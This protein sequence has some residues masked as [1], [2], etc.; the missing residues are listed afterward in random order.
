MAIDLTGINNVGEFYSH[1]YLDALLENDLKS[2]FAHWRAEE[3]DT[4]PA[5]GMNYSPD[6]ALNRCAT[7]FF[8]AKRRALRERR[9]ANRQ[10]ASHPIHVELLEALGYTYAP[11]SRYLADGAA[12]PLLGAVARDGHD[13]L[14]LAETPFVDG[15]ASPLEQMVLAAQ[16][17]DQAGKET[18]DRVIPAVPWEELVGEIFRVTNPPRWLILLAGRFIYLID[19]TKWGQ[20]Q[21]L[22]FDLDEIFGRRE[23]S[24]L[25]AT[26]ALLAREALCPTEGVPL[27]DTLD[28]N[29]HKHAYAVSS[30]LK[31]GA[32]RAVELLANE[33]VYYQRTVAK[34]ALFQDEQL[35]E[36]LTAEALTYLYRLLFLFYAEARGGELD[37]VPMKSEAF[38][39]GYSLEALRD[40]EQVAL[41]TPQAQQGYFIHASLERLFRLMEAGF[42]PQGQMTL[43]TGATGQAD[44][45]QSAADESYDSYG[46]RMN[47]LHSPLFSR[48]ST[49]LLSAVKFRNSLLQ[50]II[51][52]LSLSKEGKGRHSQRGRIS[53]AQL[54]INQLGAVY[55]GLL[56]YTGFFAQETLYEVKPADKDPDKEDVQTYFVPQSQL[57]RYAPAE[58]VYTEGP[59]GARIRKRYERGSFIFHLAGRNREKSASYYTP[60]VLTRCVVKYTLKEALQGLAADEILK[61]LICEPAMGSAA[62]INE[63]LNQ[64]ADAYLERKQAAVGVQLP[65]DQYREE[66]QRVKA[67]LASHNVYGVE[68]NPAAVELAQVSIWL[69]TIYRGAAAPWYNARLAVGNSLIGARHQFYSAEEILSGAYQN[70]APKAVRLGEPRPADSIYHWLL[71]DKGMT[72]FD[73]DKVIKELAPAAVQAIKTWRKTFTAKFTAAEVRTLQGLSARID[74]LWQQH[75]RDRQTLLARTAEPIAVWGQPSGR[76][77]ILSDSEG[78]VSRDA[79]AI[80]LPQHD[81]AAPVILSSNVILSDSEGSVSRDAS[82]TK[83]PQRDKGPLGTQH[84]DIAAKQQALE[85]LNQP[86]S[87]YRR[88]KLAMDY[89][90]ALWFWPIPAADKLPS[91]AQWLADLDSLLAGD[92]NGF[93]RMAEQ[94]A[95][96]EVDPVSPNDAAVILSGTKDLKPKNLHFADLKARNV[97]DLCRENPR[98]ALAAEVAQRQRFHHWE[99]VF[100]EVFAGRGGFDLMVGNPPWVKLEWKEAGIL[101]EYDPAFAIRRTSASEISEQRNTKFI[102]PQRITDYLHEF[103]EITG[104]LEYLGGQQNYPLLRGIQTNLYKCFITRAW[105]LNSVSGVTGLLHPEGVFDDSKG[106][107]LRSQIY[108][109]IRHCYRFTNVLKLFAD[110][111]HWVNFCVCIY[112]AKAESEPN[113]LFMANVFHPSTIER[114]EMHDGNGVIPGIKDDDDSWELSGHKRRLI[115]I[116]RKRLKLFAELYDAPGIAALDARLPQIH[117]EEIISVLAKFVEQPYRL[118]DITDSYFSTRMWDETGAQK[119]GTIRRETCFPTGV[120]DWIISGPH[121]YVATPLNKNPNEGCRNPLD[122]SDINLSKIPDDY[123][124]RTNYVPACSSQEYQKRIP[125][126]NGQAITKFYR[127][128]HRRMLSQTGERTLVAA[129][130]PPGVGHTNLTGSMVFDSNSVLVKF[131]GFCSSIIYD[132]VI[133]STGKGDLYEETLAR[134]AFP[135]KL[136]IDNYVISRTLRLNCLTIH[137]ADLWQELYLPTFNQDAWVRP[138]PRLT[139]WST[140]TPHWQR[141]VALRT[142]FERRQALVEID[143]LAA[144]ALDL[145]LDVLLTIYR[146]QFPVLQKNERRLRFDQRGMEVPMKTSGGELGPDETHPDFAAMIPPFTPVDR[147]EDY[148]VAWRVFGERLG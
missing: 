9:P 89:W 70:Q 58:F 107:L 53:Y 78:S 100:A 40:L 92:A 84:V 18:E 17:A 12:L 93:E 24:T 7:P 94:L 132:F 2:L 135:H 65:P 144:M 82:A 49:P 80:K 123:L 81:N 46:F 71:P 69:N 141:H 15:D 127:H 57:E 47:G 25:R 112:K 54:G 73:N 36:K 105:E 67:Y 8:D 10:R 44:G 143:V 38:R 110:I 28:E 3:A 45:T 52:L 39:T 147:E 90:C 35:A 120:E 111:L 74:E 23:R 34:Q 37:L 142:P 51:Q 27:H 116:D 133:K 102:N 6:R 4:A 62:F 114:A 140:L 42:H 33:Y 113:I 77:V 106:T 146:V 97:D 31:F 75:L 145:T 48:K 129:I 117:S 108:L 118:G 91:R 64:L 72:A 138:D 59:D 14:W 55:E 126:W 32:R 95:L 43:L 115:H 13:Y 1:H 22:L 134:L 63:M 128:V 68:L 60:E 125:K 41:T 104:T 148:R 103:A 26:A 119:Q 88:L 21:Y 137:Y 66:R 56:S 139:P 85:G 76:T 136:I 96:Y 121:F 98:L 16:Y 19:R 124:P 131:S 79:S 20:G 61:L 83:R 87:A 29:S 130:I 99:L 5:A 30:D 11:Q 101:S 122:Y 50:E 86:T 109:Q